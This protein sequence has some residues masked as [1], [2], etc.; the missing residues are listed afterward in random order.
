MYWNLFRAN[1]NF[2]LRSTFVYEGIYKFKYVLF[3]YSCLL[4]LPS[5]SYPSFLS[6]LFPSCEPISEFF[7]DIQ[8]FMMYRRGFWELTI[9]HLRWGGSLC[10][11]FCTLY[12]D[13]G[14]HLPQASL[15]Q[16]SVSLQGRS[17]INCE[18]QVIKYS[19]KDSWKDEVA[20]Q[21]VLKQWRKFWVK[22]VMKL[23]IIPVG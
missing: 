16:R 23:D 6:F 1:L 18:C 2:W 12:F 11:I 3:C 15:S 20:V 17:C 7:P 5:Y 10:L 9:S 14:S 21:P 13:H 8:H 19:E 4:C 22:F